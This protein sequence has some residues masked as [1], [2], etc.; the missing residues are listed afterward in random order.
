M[1]KFRIKNKFGFTLIEL[2]VVIA[3]ISLLAA[4]LLPGLQRSRE[5]GRRAV[6]IGNLRQLGMALLMYAQDNN[7]WFPPGVWET[8]ASLG[9]MNRY[10]NLKGNLFSP[11][12]SN[13]AKRPKGVGRLRRDGYVDTYKVFYCPNKPLYLESWDYSPGGNETSISYGYY[14]NV[15]NTNPGYSP[16]ARNGEDLRDASDGGWA[17]NTNINNPSLVLMECMAFDPSL[18]GSWS[19]QNFQCHTRVNL[20][21]SNALYL[22][23]SVSWRSTSI[24]YS[25]PLL[26][27][28]GNEYAL[29]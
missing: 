17:R 3:I 12:D 16:L 25:H 11:N 14:V 13:L 4:M 19:L 15:S 24:F 6:C 22:D 1:A 27:D 9:E 23:G 21:G 8:P 26:P 28:A 5:L 2:L 18:A 20:E 7:G 29:Y 10:Y